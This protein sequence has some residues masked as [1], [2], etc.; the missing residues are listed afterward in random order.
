MSVH[1]DFFCKLWNY[2][3]PD[4]NNYILRSVKSILKQLIQEKN[5]YS[6]EKLYSHDITLKVIEET[7]MYILM[8]F[9][10][11]S[12]RT[13]IND[14]QSDQLKVNELQRKC[15]TS[16]YV[17]RTYS[18]FQAWFATVV[19][20]CNLVISTAFTFLLIYFQFLYRRF[21]FKNFFCYFII[22][23]KMAV[24]LWQNSYVICLIFIQYLNL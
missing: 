12:F 24:L 19:C 3:G 15:S 11:I 13:V 8:L 4:K 20:F 5:Y 9:E 10:N 1:F 23:I 7:S 18:C 14:F 2:F 6:L 16:N 17:T 22:K 21:C